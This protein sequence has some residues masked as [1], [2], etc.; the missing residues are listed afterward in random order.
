MAPE[1]LSYSEALA[2]N[3]YDKQEEH[4]ESTRQQTSYLMKQQ[5][6]LCQCRRA[7]LQ[8]LLRY[9][10]DIPWRGHVLSAALPF[11]HCGLNVTTSGLGGLYRG[12]VR[13][14]RLFSS[15][16]LTWFDQSEPLTLPERLQTPNQDLLHNFMFN[17]PV[18]L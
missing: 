10:V 9:N 12:V 5:I 16:S 14:E 17:S 2:E 3:I 6:S 4:N 18:I 1:H 11:S 15:V 8:W 13:S 7:E